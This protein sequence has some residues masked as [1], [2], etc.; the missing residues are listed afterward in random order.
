MKKQFYLLTAG[1]LLACLAHAQLKK[2]DVMLG[3]NVNFVIQ[4]ST[5]G[6]TTDNARQTSYSLMPAIGKFVKDGLLVGLDVTYGH[7]KYNSGSTPAGI[8][9]SDY[10]GLGVFARQ[11]KMLGSGFALFGEGDL[12]GQYSTSNYYTEGAPK[13]SPTQSYTIS[14]GFYPGLAYFISRHVQLERGIQNLAYVKF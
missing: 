4:N 10:Y 5:P 14:A 11:Y 7:N 2:G 1:L 13:P 3:G 8:N 6:G 12:G 9:V